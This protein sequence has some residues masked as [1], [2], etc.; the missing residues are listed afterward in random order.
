MQEIELMLNEI[1][2]FAED[3]KITTLMFIDYKFEFNQNDRFE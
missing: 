3:I 2:D 1:A